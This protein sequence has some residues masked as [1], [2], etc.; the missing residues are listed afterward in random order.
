MN[1]T[2]MNTGVKVVDISDKKDV[3]RVAIAEGCIKLKDGTLKAITENKIKKGDVLS[4]ASTAAILAVKKTPELIPMCHPI[5]VTSIDVTFTINN[6]IRVT[7]TVKSMG[8]T[9]VEMEA[10]TGVSAA[11]ITIWDMVKYLEKDKSGNYP[12]TVIE[13]IRVVK[14]VKG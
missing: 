6:G 1:L 5:P 10:I 4:V 11:L 7:C 3:P 14:K 12:D 2:G 9:G 13:N 8:K